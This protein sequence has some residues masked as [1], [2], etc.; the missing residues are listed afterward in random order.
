[1]L[2]SKLNFDERKY[3]ESNRLK[4]LVVSEPSNSETDHN[5]VNTP[6]TPKKLNRNRSNLEH[7]DT[8]AQIFRKRTIRSSYNNKAIGDRARSY[9]TEE[10]GKSEIEMRTFP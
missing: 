9:R 1:M 7:I 4:K 10:S 6:T 2:K 8:T 3:V 5:N